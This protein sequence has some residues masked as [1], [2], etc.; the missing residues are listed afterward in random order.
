MDVIFSGFCSDPRVIII[1]RMKRRFGSG[2][3]QNSPE[4]TLSSF[5]QVFGL[6]TCGLFSQDRTHADINPPSVPLW[7]ANVKNQIC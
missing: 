4:K 7:L 1:Y 6:L 2:V 3:S 5:N